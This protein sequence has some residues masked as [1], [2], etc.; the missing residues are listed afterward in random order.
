[1]VTSAIDKDARKEEEMNEG[2]WE[3]TGR[4]EEEREGEMGGG[5]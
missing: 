5:R 2:L 4:K 3:G 1:M